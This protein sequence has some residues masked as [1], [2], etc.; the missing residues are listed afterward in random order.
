MDRTK[1]YLTVVYCT[2]DDSLAGKDGWENGF[3]YGGLK[4]TVQTNK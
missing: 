1:G 2:V 4:T 3:F